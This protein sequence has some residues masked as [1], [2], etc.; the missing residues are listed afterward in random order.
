MIRGLKEHRYKL[1]EGILIAEG[2]HTVNIGAGI[3]SKR[4]YFMN[5]L[6]EG[7]CYSK[8]VTA[9]CSTYD[10]RFFRRWGSG[11][12]SKA[13]VGMLVKVLEG[14]DLSNAPANYDLVIRL[15]W[16]EGKFPI[17]VFDYIEN[18][19]SNNNDLSLDVDDK[20]K[21]STVLDY[22][23]VNSVFLEVIRLNPMN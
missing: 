21:L 3:S 9:D 8:D 7:V 18:L 13:I 15:V 11:A 12:A 2:V 22:I 4:W 10:R 6:L 23:K 1:R 17:R 5:N 19:C 20:A 16:S 14:I